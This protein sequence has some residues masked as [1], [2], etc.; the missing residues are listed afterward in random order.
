IDRLSCAVPCRQM[1]MSGVFYHPSTDNGGSAAAAAAANYYSEQRQHGG[2]GI[3]VID[4]DMFRN[5]QGTSSDVS[6]FD[7]FTAGIEY[8]SADSPEAA[9]Q[10][11]ASAAAS[12]SSG[13]LQPGAMQ[14]RSD[15]QQVLQQQSL[16]PPAAH[17]HH[18]LFMGAT[19]AHMQPFLNYDSMVLMPAGAHHLPQQ[20]QQP[21]PALFPGGHQ[22]F[23]A[24][25]A[26][27]GAV[28]STSFLPFDQM[29]VGGQLPTVHH[30]ASASMSVHHHHQQQQQVQHM[31]QQHAAAAAAAAAA[32]LHPYSASASDS[33][34]Q[35]TTVLMAFRQ[36]GEETEFVRKAIE[37]LVKKLKDKRLEL[38]ALIQAVTSNGKTPTGCV[39]IQRS[40]DGRL[41]VAG[42]KG[43]PH[44]VYARIWRWPNVAKTEL[45]KLP[46]CQIAHDNQDFICINPY[47]YERVVSNTGMMADQQSSKRATAVESPSNYSMFD[48][49]ADDWAAQMP[50]A[51]AAAI[52]AD[53]RLQ[54]HQAVMLQQQQ[55]GDAAE[56]KSSIFPAETAAMHRSHSVDLSRVQIPPASVY[57]TH[58]CTINYFEHDTQVGESFKV[59]REMISITVDGGLDPQGERNGR[60]CIGSIP[61]VHRQSAVEIVR[62]HIGPGVVLKQHQDGR[63]TMEVRSNKAIFVRAPYV[64]YVKHSPYGQTIHKFQQ[65][66]GEITIFDLRWAYYEM[67]EQTASA[68][69]AV[70]AQARA[71]AGL[72]VAH[73]GMQQMSEVVAGSGVDEMKRAFCTV[74][75]SFVKGFGGAYNRK[76][77]KDCPC[78]IEMELHRPLQLLDQLLKRSYI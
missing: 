63:V 22:L 74:G 66:D 7:W 73:P 28:P 78:W 56:F 72:P 21:H 64:D 77:L 71:V 33:S 25:S 54:Q 37:S 10:Q 45:A 18:H 16:Q 30:P 24:C 42:R 44:V 58:W 26:Q 19:A 27:V 55:P 15:V 17:H 52:A 12:I 6:S 67:C 39:T 40:L 36:G 65:G 29:L 69:E 76:T 9:Q 75:M 59:R 62:M 38:E 1:E 23:S 20:Q 31:Q 3:A 49:R 61:N 57:P 35:I 51:S 48:A 13:M 34:S 50:P 14:S 47:H 2:G 4:Q 41:Q 53:M 5:E 46:M 60:F 11:Q 68:K 32:A 8:T 43:V 70:V